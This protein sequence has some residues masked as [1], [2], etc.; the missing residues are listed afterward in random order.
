LGL[1]AFSRLA[2]EDLLLFFAGKAE[3]SACQQR[4]ILPA[5]VLLGLFSTFGKS[6]THVQLV[7]KK[8][9]GFL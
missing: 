5:F 2:R 8:Y 9:L 4:V 3:G 7:L 1:Q 6:I